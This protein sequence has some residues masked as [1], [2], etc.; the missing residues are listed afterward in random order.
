MSSQELEP[1][2][3]Y[4]YTLQAKKTGEG[5]FD[6]PTKAEVDAYIFEALGLKSENSTE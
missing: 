4:R 6:E 1:K 5:L 2:Y 3:Q